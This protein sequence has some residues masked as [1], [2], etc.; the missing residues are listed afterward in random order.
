[1]TAIDFTG[2]N[3]PPT[4]NGSLHNIGKTKTE[5]EKIISAIDDILDL[6]ENSYSAYGFGAKPRFNGK[7]EPIN[8][9][10]SLSG[11]PN[12]TSISDLN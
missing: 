8:H 9:C 12:K 4:F 2:S 11:D 3:G 7:T 1:M 5:Y 6:K 10:F